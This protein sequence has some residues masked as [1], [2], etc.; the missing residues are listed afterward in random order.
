MARAREKD[1][2]A[3]AKKKASRPSLVKSYRKVLVYG[4]NKK[5][6]STFG[7]SNGVDNTLVLDPEQGTDLMLK[8]DPYRIGIEQWEDLHDAWGALRT[9]K[10]SPKILG[11]GKSTEPFNTVSLDGCTKFNNMALKYVRRL[12]EER[13]L[14]RI[15]GMTDRRDYS[16]SGELMKDMINNFLKLKMNVIFTAQ[17]RMMTLA[18][19]D[20][21]DDS[22]EVS[23]YYVPDLPAAVRGALN[24]VVDVIGRI[25]VVRTEIKGKEKAQRRLQIG[26]HPLYDTG[27][28]SDFV[29]PDMIRNPTFPRLV[30]L[31]ETGELVRG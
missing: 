23:E 18:S 1:Y 3:I 9:Y 11:L 30:N 26:H 28:R 19:A 25:Y 12:Q 13:D 8:K 15:P 14:D 2:L 20:D 31:I 4:R 27:Y 22:E 24:S 7:I 16:K 5:G 29:L 21:D 6:K 17:E 10:L